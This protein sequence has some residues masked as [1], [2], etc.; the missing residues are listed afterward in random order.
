MHDRRKYVTYRHVASAVGAAVRIIGLGVDSDET[1]HAG[2][3]L[4]QTHLAA[5][6]PA[7]FRPSWVPLG[8]LV[9]LLALGCLDVFAAP[10]ILQA[11]DLLVHL[12]GMGVHEPLADLHGQ[13][14]RGR[15]C[16]GE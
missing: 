12:D 13:H 4:P 2:L 11:V 6:H 15:R 16:Q 10:L 9:V 5:R 14:Q 8:L 7:S 3:V 1:V